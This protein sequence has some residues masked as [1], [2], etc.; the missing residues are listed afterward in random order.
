[1][2]ITLFSVIGLFGDK[3]LEMIIE[4]NKLIIVAENGSG[5]TIILRLF[6]LF[7]SKQWNDLL[8][9]EF[10]KIIATVN[11]SE[12]VFHKAD[13]LEYDIPNHVI[14]QLIAEYPA[15]KQFFED[16]LRKYKVDELLNNEFIVT[17][18]ASKYDVPESLLY[19]VRNELSEI[20][21]K[22]DKY[23]WNASFLYLPTY[24]RIERGFKRLFGD[25]G[26]R[27]ESH[28]IQLIP[29]IDKRIQEE[30]DLNGSSFSETENDIRSIFDTIWSTRDLERWTLKNN[31]FC[32][33]LIEFGM[34]DVQFRIS[35]YIANFGEKSE[36]RILF[37][38]EKCNKYLTTNKKL[39]LTSNG[40]RLGIKVNDCE[41]VFSL[42]ILSAGE[43]HIISL[44]S[45]LLN[46]SVNIWLIIDEPE[47]SLSMKWQE[48]LL[49][50]AL[51]FNLNGMLVATHSPF[52]VS[53]ELSMY[54]HGFNE[55]DKEN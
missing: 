3:N 19:S 43:K 14:E 30:K 47:I 9:Y 15:Y 37:Y 51:E 27:L 6:Y 11:G 46:K 38:L 29:E 23:D 20:R 7:F 33:E 1:M 55:F 32:F 39:I 26:K 24:R 4:D 25:M 16:D 42:D 48:Q 17:D 41:K 45:Y 36:D 34:D 28:L 31:N 53:S 21:N 5:K 54:T 8:E 12:F 2:N 10:E 49:A 22:D 13:Y 52:V 40:K 35:N 44:F 50:D 18:I